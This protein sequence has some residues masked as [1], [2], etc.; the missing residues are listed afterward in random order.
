MDYTKSAY[1]PFGYSGPRTPGEPAMTNLEPKLIVKLTSA[2]SATM[3]LE[4]F[5]ER[6][7][8]ESRN[9]NASP[10]VQ[11]ESYATSKDHVRSSNVRY[12]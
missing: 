5:F 9:G 6:E 8:P 11:P 1:R 3:R 12:T 4:G 7:D 2:P 10:F